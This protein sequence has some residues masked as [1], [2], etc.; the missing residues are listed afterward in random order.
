MARSQSSSKGQDEPEVTTLY[1]PD[2]R[3]YRTA[4]STE[5]TRLKSSGYSEEA[6]P[7]EEAEQV[8]TSEEA[9]VSGPPAPPTL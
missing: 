4:S 6:P 3:E 5:V 1:A 2:G 7:K 8:R 9:Q